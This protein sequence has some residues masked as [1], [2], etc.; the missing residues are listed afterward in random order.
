[1][2]GVALTVTQGEFKVQSKRKL[3][4]FSKGNLEG[5]K[6][7]KERKPDQIECSSLELR[8]EEFVSQEEIFVRVERKM[9]QH[10]DK[11]IGRRGS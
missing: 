10:S 2:K 3:A 8:G 4:Q 5:T 1:M 11:S 7:R 6:D 9:F